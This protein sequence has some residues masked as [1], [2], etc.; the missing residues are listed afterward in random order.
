MG[1]A[2][3][4][5]SEK[6]SLEG[7]LSQTSGCSSLQGDANG[8]VAGGKDESMHSLK[9]AADSQALKHRRAWISGEHKDSMIQPHDS[10]D[11]ARIAQV[12]KKLNAT[13][14]MLSK[15]QVR[16]MLN[17]AVGGI[18]TMLFDKIFALFDVHGNDQVD[19][20]D[21]VVALS[22]LSQ[23]GSARNAVDLAF[24]LFDV[25][26]S[27]EMSKPEFNSM[28][29]AI[30]CNRLKHALDTPYGRA[31]FRTHMENEWSL[32]SIKFWE[33]VTHICDIHGNCESSE[34]SGAAPSKSGGIPVSVARQLFDQYICEN[35]PEQINIAGITQQAIVEELQRA[36]EC[37][38]PTVPVDVFRQAA[39]EIMQLM[40]MDNFER[41]RNQ[42]ASET[43]RDR[44][45]DILQVNYAEEAWDALG[46]GPD[47]LMSREQFRAWAKDNPT[48]FHF[49]EDIREALQPLFTDANVM[50]SAMSL[51]SMP[52]GSA[53]EEQGSL[54]GG[55]LLPNEENPALTSTGQKLS[56]R[57]LRARSS[58][59]STARRISRGSENTYDLENEDLSA[60]SADGEE[61]GASSPVGVLFIETSMEPLAGVGGGGE[62]GMKRS[63][64][65]LSIGSKGG[66]VAMPKRLYQRHGTSLVS[67]RTAMDSDGRT[68]R[69]FTVDSG[70][71]SRSEG[72]SPFTPPPAP[73]G[74]PLGAFANEGDHAEV[75][76]R[77]VVPSY[78]ESAPGALG[79]KPV[80]TPPLR[81]TRVHRIQDSAEVLDRSAEGNCSARL[82]FLL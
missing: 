3:S 19:K 41:F 46:L 76:P 13:D 4:S 64:S 58:T 59:N 74:S 16:T 12:L 36:A 39:E 32:E 48:Y 57:T 61:L 81:E 72:G 80:T 50:D 63:T 21:F 7:S 71:A 6:V 51:H 14:G 53:G 45:G 10:S 26:A 65:N 40:E 34:G 49:L 62:T 29:R 77:H 66:S 43:E 79:G 22:F 17:R 67:M 38:E 75:P 9:S 54:K 24:R 78:S 47:D 33:T 30:M 44:Q 52:E 25:D 11:K 27:G 23:Q 37:G 69:V 28:I 1:C 60:G 5:A 68:V 73:P 8:S 70:A 35:A 2:C 15:E 55:A 18:E 31:A 42:L 82:N 20:H 56:S